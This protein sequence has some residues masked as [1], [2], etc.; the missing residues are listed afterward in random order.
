MKREDRFT[1]K[2]S[3]FY[4]LVIFATLAVTGVTAL[5]GVVEYGSV[6]AGSAAEAR[7]A[8]AAEA[9]PRERAVYV[10]KAGEVK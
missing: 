4:A 2:D 7:H 8:S 1:T 5:I 9:R 6:F 3:F 10:A